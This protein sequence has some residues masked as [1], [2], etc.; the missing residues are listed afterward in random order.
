MLNESSVF[1]LPRLEDLSVEEISSTSYFPSFCKSLMASSTIK[2]LSLNFSKLNSFHVKHLEEVFSSMMTLTKL[3]FIDGECSL[4]DFELLPIFT[5]LGKNRR[6][7][8]VD[9]SFIDID[10]EG[11]CDFLLPIFS[12]PTLKVFKL[13]WFAYLCSKFFLALQ[14][15]ESLTVV[16]M[17]YS[18]FTDDNAV[19]LG[20]VF[21]F[22]NVLKKYVFQCSI[23]VFHQCLTLL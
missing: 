7:T 23:L 5:A 21:K 14:K 2:T 8:E 17:P 11:Y 3:K 10:G 18:Q 20:E 22:N 13:T 6:L 16:E 19:E 12:I 4:L 9:V 15:N 1:F